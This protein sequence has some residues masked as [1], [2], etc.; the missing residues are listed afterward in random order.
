MLIETKPVSETVIMTNPVGKA[1]GPQLLVA[2]GLP[3]GAVIERA[4]R[5]SGK[6]IG[7]ADAAIAGRLVSGRFDVSEARSL[8]RQ[9]AA[10]L[11]LDVKEQA[12]GYVLMP[13]IAH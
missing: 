4:N 13:K 10:A 1:G 12:G 7:L 6:K 2:D 8:A 5:V 3:L 9:L 11:D